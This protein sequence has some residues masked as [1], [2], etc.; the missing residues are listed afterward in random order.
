MQKPNNFDNTQ[1]SGVKTPVELGGH[2]MIIKGVREQQSRTGKDMI[3]V[4][5]DFSSQDK[6]PNY[7]TEK[8]QEDTREEKKWPFQATQ[9][10]VVND[11]QGNCSRSFKTFCTCV[12]RSNKGFIINWETADF[13]AQFK[14]KLIGGVFGNVESEYNGEYYTRPELRWFCEYS[15]VADQKVPDDKNLPAGGA[16]NYRAQQPSAR[17][18]PVPAKTQMGQNN[19]VAQPLVEEPD[20]PF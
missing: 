15:K 10:I 18:Q 19:S 7:F 20:I 6:Q 3:V 8:F 14:G 12:E 9:Y 13:C 11:D 4:A 2:Y 1:A 5:F 17:V 16:S